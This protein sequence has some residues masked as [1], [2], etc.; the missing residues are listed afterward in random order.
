M[1]ISIALSTGNHAA[2]SRKLKAQPSSQSLCLDI[3]QWLRF[4][5]T[6]VARAKNRYGQW[7]KH[8][9]SSRLKP[10]TLLDYK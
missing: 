1:L 3:A 6:S 10:N 4:I 5:G 8:P 2:R 9:I 7:T